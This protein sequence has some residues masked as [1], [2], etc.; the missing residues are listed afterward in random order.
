MNNEKIA[1]GTGFM[2]ETQGLK[3]YKSLQPD[4]CKPLLFQTQD[5]LINI[6]HCLK[7]QRLQINSL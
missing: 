6:S 4:G 5:K 7:Y 3:S 2:Q 1:K